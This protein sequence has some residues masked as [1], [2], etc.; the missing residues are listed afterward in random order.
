M[1]FPSLPTGRES[2]VQLVDETIRLSRSWA[3]VTSK[4]ISSTTML[5][6]RPDCYRDRLL[7]APDRER[8]CPEKMLL[9]KV[10]VA[11]KGYRYPRLKLSTQLGPSRAAMPKR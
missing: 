11:C 2:A 10:L 1:I 6:Q 4:P 3:R 8:S 9:F 5:Q 7:N